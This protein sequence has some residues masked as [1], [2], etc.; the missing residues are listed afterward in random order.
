MPLNDVPNLKIELFVKEKDKTNFNVQIL[1]TS[2]T[3]EWN[4]NTI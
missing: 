4:N 2:R 1:I 3:S